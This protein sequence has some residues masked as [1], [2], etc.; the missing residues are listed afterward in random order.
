LPAVKWELVADPA[1][2]AR[3]FREA[4]RVNDRF[5]QNTRRAFD[6]GG[7]Q[8]G[9]L[10]GARF[11]KRLGAG[12][13]ASVGIVRSAAG[14]IGV[15]FAAAGI[16][17]FATD[18]VKAAATFDKTMRQV[19]AVAKLPTRQ[20]AD[21]RR[22]ALDMGAKTSFSAKQASEAMLELAKGGMTAAQIK[23]GGLR[24]TLT[25]AA[26]G[27]LELGEAANTVIKSLGQFGLGVDK[28]ADV[29]AALAGGANA[30]T[31]SVADLSEAL[32]QVGPG[33]RN[34]GLSLQ[35]TVAVLAE[36]SDN[37]IRGSDAGT[38]LK[39]MLTNLVPQTAKA[40]TAMKELGIQFVD[41]HGSIK[42]V[43]EV[44]QIL[45]DRLGKLTEA[46]RIQALQ[47]LF[48]SDATRAATVLMNEGAGGLAKYIKATNDRGAAEQL[49]K[50]N[51]EGAS[52]A[53]ERLQGAIET[54]QIEIGTAFL[55]K[56]ADTAEWLAVKIP[57]ALDTLK[58]GLRTARDW[59]EKNKDE[60]GTLASTLSTLFTPAAGDANI[61]IGDLSKSLGGLRGVFDRILWASLETT[62]DFIALARFVGNLELRILDL[63][64]A[65]GFAVN[66][67]SRLSGGS[68]HAADSMIAWARDMRDKTRVQLGKLAEDA[69]TTQRQID[70]LHGKT[71]DIKVNWAQPHAGLAGLS[72]KIEG[73]PRAG[74]GLILGHGGPRDDKAGLYALSNRE[75]VESAA[76]VD[77]YG[78]P[79]M[80][81]LNQRQV[82]RMADGG[83][84]G[85]QSYFRQMQRDM[86]PLAH[87]LGMAWGRVLQKLGGAGSPAIKAF[88]RAAD[89]HP[90][91]WG[92]V[93]PGGWDCSG[94]T[95]S[96]M[97]LMRHQNPYRRYFTT[98]S[99]FDALGFTPGLGGTYQIGVDRDHG[100]MVGRYGGLPFEAESTRTGIK[101]GAA[102]SSVTSFPQVYHMARGGLVGGLDPRTL[103]WLAKQRGIAI[104]GDP[105]K[106]RIERFDAGGYLRPGL[107]L[108]YNGTGRPEP[109]GASAGPVTI[110]APITIHA[111]P[112]MSEQRVGQIVADHIEQVRARAAKGRRA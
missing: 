27:G 32:A 39:T 1:K 47:T 21:L 87:R 106:L 54:V 28:A 2:Y 59:W 102:A 11:N 46:Q 61:S 3:G 40:R 38:S 110:N 111:A 51:T 10:F 75:F 109:V 68:G 92:G 53:F 50:S 66:A 64:V 90:Y 56:L 20:L 93:G 42:P 70:R 45:H 100:H 44:A 52:G 98:A 107:N 71:V 105:G 88:I 67:I 78:V 29:A 26:A 24:H 23:A 97:A 73:G 65:A 76:A 72:V 6:R 112:G 33:A 31:A 79:F 49:A 80:E 34:A 82:P 63:V 15:A 17:K 77:Y 9:A 22:V 7:D 89:A 62:K 108:A 83:F 14:A 81:A 13:S 5:S 35:Q 74:G 103:D 94:L 99:N 60:V 19:A 12:F 55:P 95:G 85:T 43:T 96:V 8:A 25:L 37:G 36:F 41:A 91:V 16:A 4:E 69:R 104:G 84:V 101:V 18:S 86:E 30:S 58:A 57:A 48:G